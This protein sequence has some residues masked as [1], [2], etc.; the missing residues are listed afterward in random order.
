VRQIEVEA[1]KRLATIHEM[2]AAAFS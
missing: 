1:L 2:E